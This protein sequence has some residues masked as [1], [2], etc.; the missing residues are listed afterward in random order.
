MNKE[1]M[2]SN[3]LDFMSSVFEKEF[4]GHDKFHTLR[5]LS[6]AERIAEEE[7][8]DLFKV[9]LAAILHDV[10]D[11]KLSPETNPGLDRASGFMKA[12]GVDPTTREAVCQ[13][14][15][16]I[17]FKGS[18]S[19]KP[20][21]IEGMCV[22]DADRLDAIGAVGVAR[23]FAYGGSKGRPLYDPEVMPLGR[24]NEEQYRKSGSTSVNHF[25]EKLFLLK[26]MMNTAS[27]KR[28]AEARDAFMHAFIEEFLAEWAGE[29]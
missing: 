28:T 1:Q 29:R 24:M 17:S 12:N 7:G 9:R 21:T 3:A 18:D 27:A 11:I 23:A 14:I 16:E 8:A 13:I 26:D 6:T 10:D 5:V 4:S 2:I 19:V 25:Y 15:R 22:Q 20:S